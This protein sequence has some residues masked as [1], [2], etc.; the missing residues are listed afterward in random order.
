MPGKY[1][2]YIIFFLIL[3]KAGLSFGNVA[4]ILKDTSSDVR[5]S[6]LKSDIEKVVG[7]HKNLAAGIALLNENRTIWV[8]GVGNDKPNHPASENTMFRTASVSK[9]LVALSILKLQE[10]GKLKLSDKIKDIIPEVQF[11]NPWESTDP[12]RIV[13]LLEHTS[14]WDEIHLVEMTHNQTPPIPLKQAL[15]FHTHSRKSRWVPGSRMAYCNSGYAVAAYVIE[16][17]SGMRYEDYVRKSIFQPLGMNHSSFLMD[18]QYEKWGAQMYNWAMQKVSYKHELYRPAAS[19]N[20]S[21]ADMAKIVSLLLKHGALDTIQFLSKESVLRMESPKSTPGALSGLQQGYGLANR[22]SYYK[23]FTYQGHDGAMDGGLSELAY[24]P[25]KGLGHVI[26]LN[27][28]NGSVMQEISTLIREFETEAL[29]PAA[30]ENTSYKGDIKVN[31]GYY[32]SINPRSQNR[33]YQDLILNIEQLEVFDDRVTMSWIVPGPKRTYYPV[34]ANQFRYENTNKIGLV[35][36]ID[37]IAGKVLYTDTAVLQPISVVRVFGQLFILLIWV[38]M[39]VSVFLLTLILLPL[40]FINYK[41]YAG[42][43]RLTLPATITSIF[44]LSLIILSRIPIPGSDL[45]LS[46]PSVLSVSFL[47]LSVLFVIAAGWSLLDVY[48]VKKQA[49][50]RLIFWAALLLSCLHTLAAIYLIALNVI[51]FVSWA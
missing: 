50:G 5:L 39:M 32:V 44:M 42:A 49:G 30:Y 29:Q 13:H 37:P 46:K 19:L 20:S 1:F 21:A 15:E 7:R 4:G 45:L 28:N 17:L 24:L 40:G 18:K 35:E 9:M 16:K 8:S 23:G 11:E 3:F 25:N 41:K 36:A 47:I 14:G 12:V 33:F 34:S 27:A 22:S 26:L 51:P 6:K 10:E 48:R 31:E 2:V 43:L 38:F